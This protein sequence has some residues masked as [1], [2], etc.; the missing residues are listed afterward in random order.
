MVYSVLIYI[1]KVKKK[2]K[3]NIYIERERERERAG[4]EGIML[5]I[6]CLSSASVERNKMERK[7]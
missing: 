3:K 1:R 7:I 5:Y 4:A 6:C 2:K